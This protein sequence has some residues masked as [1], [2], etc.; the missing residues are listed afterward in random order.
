[1]I[2]IPRKARIKSEFGIYH[3]IQRGNEKKNIFRNNCDRYKYIEVLIK[4]KEKYNFLVHGY[5]L[6]DNHIHILLDTNGK[7]MSKIMQSISVSY[8]I[9]FNKTYDRCGHLFQDRFRSEQVLNDEYLMEV[10]RYIHNNPV[11]AGIVNNLTEYIWTSFGKYIGKITKCNEFVET[12]LVLGL[13][14]K[15][16]SQAVTDYTHFMLRDDCDSKF[17]ERLN[18]FSEPTLYLEK[19][20]R[21]MAEAQKILSIFLVKNNIEASDLNKHI[22]IRNTL[23]KEIRGKTFLALWQIGELFGGLSAP[24]VSRICKNKQE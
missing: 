7:D 11:K 24:V 2:T 23:I 8:A 10:S 12:K 3:V 16:K 19:H 14:A 20:I 15:S 4:A 6:M 21:N 17:L 5:C 18:D 13:F 22:S 9:Y 1:M